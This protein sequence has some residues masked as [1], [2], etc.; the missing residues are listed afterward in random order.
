VAKPGRKSTP[1]PPPQPKRTHHLRFSFEFYDAGGARYCLSRFDSDQ[2]R[3]ALV[4]LKE[5]N[6]NTLQELQDK[7]RVLHFHD[8]RWEDTAEKKGFPV[9]VPDDLVPF[10]FALL[11][12]NNQRARVFGGLAASTLT[13]YIVWFD[14]DHEVWP[15]TR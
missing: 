10:Q 12:I 6:Q 2:V 9:E 1:I 13:F 3:L 8:V 15:S 11:G 4:R 14:L 5:V 7:R